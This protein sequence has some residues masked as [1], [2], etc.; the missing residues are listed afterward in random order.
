MAAHFDEA[1]R[2]PV[3]GSAVCVGDSE[4]NATSDMVAVSAGFARW[5]F[6]AGVGLAGAVDTASVPNQPLEVNSPIGGGVW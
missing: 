1:S 2:I 5:Q 6:H 4:R 3:A